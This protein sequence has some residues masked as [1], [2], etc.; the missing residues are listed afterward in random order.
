MEDGGS[1]LSQLSGVLAENVQ[2]RDPHG[3]AQRSR[4]HVEEGSGETK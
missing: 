3:R 1:W 4:P 2:Y